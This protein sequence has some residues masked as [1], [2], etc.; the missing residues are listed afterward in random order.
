MSLLLSSLHVL[1]FWTAICLLISLSA[2]VI[3][4]DKH[5]IIFTVCESALPDLTKI[6][7]LS[8]LSWFV[9][10]HIFAMFCVLC[11]FSF[12]LSVP[13][14]GSLHCVWQ[15]WML[16]CLSNMYWLCSDIIQHLCHTFLSQLSSAC[17]LFLVCC[18]SSPPPLRCLHAKHGA[19]YMLHWH[20]MGAV[21]LLELKYWSTAASNHRSKHK[22]TANIAIFNCCLCKTK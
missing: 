18:A 12:I 7:F 8:L 5:L 14:Y 1:Y 17:M 21:I 13:G 19:T 2:E 20:D 6:P 11:S 16:R 3:F 4:S 15:I 9:L 22:L 10:H